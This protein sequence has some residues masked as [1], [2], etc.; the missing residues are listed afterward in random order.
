MMSPGQYYVGDLCYV[1][2]DRWNE[3]CDIICQRNESGNLNEGE[4]SLSD[5]TK[6]AVYRTKWGDGVYQD[7]HGKNYPVDAGIIGCVAVKNIM[8]ESHN[9]GCAL[10]QVFKFDFDFTTYTNDS[11]IHFGHVLIDTD[12]GINYD[13]IDFEDEEAV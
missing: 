2:E 13:Y 9:A 8:A 11:I 6:F 1:L 5:G 12:P 4:F 7:Q 10:G 3:V